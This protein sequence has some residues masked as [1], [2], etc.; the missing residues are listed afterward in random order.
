[1]ARSTRPLGKVLRKGGFGYLPQEPRI[2]GHLEGRNAVTHVLSGRGIDEA[3]ERIEKLRIA[4]EEEA[5]D[6]NV[7]RYS[8]AQERVRDRRV[9]TRPRARR[10]ASP[11]ASG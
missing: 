9:A 3:M 6:R 8:K 7:A 4:M 5:S 11:P 1:M 10:A 2:A